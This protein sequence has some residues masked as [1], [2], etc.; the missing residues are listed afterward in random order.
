MPRKIRDLIRD[1]EAVGFKDRGGRGDHRNFVHPK[2]VKPVTLSGK[3]GDDAKHYQEKA[4]RAAIKE[5]ER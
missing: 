5:S 3:P 1:L 2:V 4:I